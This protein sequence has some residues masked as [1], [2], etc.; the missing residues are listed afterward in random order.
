MRP[1]TRAALVLITLTLS[2]YAS[3]CFVF[4]AIGAASHMHSTVHARTSC[5]DQ[6]VEATSSLPCNR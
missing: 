6:S 4:A 1:F 3:A 2:A 5:I